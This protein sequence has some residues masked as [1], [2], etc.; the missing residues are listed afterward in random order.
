LE[1]YDFRVYYDRSVI[2]RHP[3]EVDTAKDEIALLKAYKYARGDGYLFKKH[4]M[5]IRIILFSLIRPLV[6]IFVFFCSLKIF[7]FKR[8]YY[9]MKGR[10]E[11]FMFKLK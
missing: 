6:G 5:P 9:R 7:E 11:G 1:Q 10:I 8:S 4:N 3:A 2:V